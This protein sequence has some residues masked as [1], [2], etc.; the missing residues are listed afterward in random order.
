MKLK[1][2]IC[3]DDASQR[4]YIAG[5]VEEWA[6]KNRHLTENRQY[7]DAKSFLFDYS[8]QKDFDILLLDIEMPEMNGIEL[9]KTVRR[10]NSM[11]R[12][13]SSPGFT[14]IL[15]TDLTYRPCII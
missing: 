13:Y 1:I 15:V 14:N 5:T 11:V 2:A 9:A 10:E 6:K 12:S 8:E 7:A 4:E 3:D